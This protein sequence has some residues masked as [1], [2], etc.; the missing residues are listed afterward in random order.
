[1]GMGDGGG[2]GAC[3]GA[4]VL[5]RAPVPFPVKMPPRRAA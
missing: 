2:G 3:G 4:T 1:M 5:D